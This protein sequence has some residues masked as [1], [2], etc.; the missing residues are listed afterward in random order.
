MRAAKMN[1]KNVIIFNPRIVDEL[2]RSHSMANSTNFDLLW[3]NSEDPRT[4]PWINFA[5]VPRDLCP[6]IFT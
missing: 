6:Q 2:N 5:S 1:A 4:R 3:T